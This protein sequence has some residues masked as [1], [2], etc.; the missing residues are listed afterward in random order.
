MDKQI[1]YE[2]IER[3]HK[4]YNENNTNKI[5]EN[6]ITKNGLE[7][8][9]INRQIVME[10]QPIFNIELPESKRYDQ[11]ENWKCWIYAGINVIKHNIAQ[12]LNINVM[13]LELS[14][15]YIA[16]FDKLEKSNHAYENIIALENT[17]LDYIHQE[18]IL[19]ECVT[20]AGYWLL[21]VAIVNKYGIVPKCFM[22][23][24]IESMNHKKIERIYTEKVK[25]DIACLLKMKD[26]KQSIQ[27]LENK[28]QEFLQENYELLSKIL[29][30]PIFSF[31]YE[32]K[33]KERK[34]RSYKNLTPIE[35]AN[36]FLTLNLDDFVSL[37]NM[38]MYNKSY[39]KK[40][41]KKYFGNVHEKSQVYYLNLPINVLKE[42]VIQQLKDGIPV[43]MGVYIRKFE[44]EETGIL[45]TRLYNYKETL[46]LK[47]LTKEEA[48]NLR[49]IEIHHAMTFCG[50][51]LVEDKAVRW[52]V[53]DSYGEKEKVN[54]YYI[55]NDNFFDEFVLNVMVHK[56]YLTKE[57]LELLK[58][59]PI[60]FELDEPF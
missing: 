22:P 4:H 26:E 57:T 60:Q 56:R 50:V 55:M 49:D 48:L 29:G 30:E 14:D 11:K 35:F 36:Q 18:K 59:A 21:F 31:D 7:N 47:C 13:D 53:E 24:T 23:D 3:F 34:Y 52:K 39:D 54:G 41:V 17:D 51:H 12:N 44:N 6:A 20:E 9:C 40:Y 2:Q 10:N 1:S 37:G 15:N 42:A 43:W 38:P 33:D 28:K 45:D 25:K 5:I 27:V 58:Q 8:V 46:K 19:T 16:F 32:Y